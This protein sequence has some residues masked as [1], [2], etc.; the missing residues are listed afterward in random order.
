MNMLDV[1]STNVIQP[2]SRVEYNYLFNG[3]DEEIAK[4]KEKLEKKK[5]MAMT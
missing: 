3:P 5:R 4:I 1:E 2:G